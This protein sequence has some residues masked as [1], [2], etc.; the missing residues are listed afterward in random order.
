MPELQLNDKGLI[1]AIAQDADTDDVLMLGYMSPG[2]H[3]TDPR[4]R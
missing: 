2:L 3:Q 4:G 1:P